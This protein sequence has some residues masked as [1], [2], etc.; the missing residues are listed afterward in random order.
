M[1]NQTF[2]RELVRMDRNQL[3][4]LAK[5][6]GVRV[7]RRQSID[8]IVSSL[9]QANAKGSGRKG[10]TPLSSAKLDDL[11]HGA[12]RSGQVPHDVVSAHAQRAGLV[13]GRERVKSINVAALR[14]AQG[15]VDVGVVDRLAHQQ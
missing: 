6:M 2:A 13:A 4:G 3:Q 8:S 7:Q 1:A 5:S 10:P 9:L 12:M 15:S 14:A 11:A